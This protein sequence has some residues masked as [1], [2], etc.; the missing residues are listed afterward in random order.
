[1]AKQKRDYKREA[2]IESDARREARAQRL[3]ARRA[4]IKA[5]KAERFDGKD[6][7]H[8]VAISKGG[9]NSASNLEMQ[10][11]SKN[12]SFKRNSKRQMVSETSTR[13]RKRKGK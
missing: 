13:E 9:T 12:R 7:G 2:A 11:P 3:R 4:M 8:K 5:G 6:V 10:D 1:M